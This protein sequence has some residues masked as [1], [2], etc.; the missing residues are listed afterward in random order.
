MCNR[1]R[2]C[3]TTADDA[4]ES[5]RGHGATDGISSHAMG[6][7]Y[8]YEGNQTDALPRRFSRCRRFRLNTDGD[9]RP[10]VRVVGAR[11]VVHYERNTLTFARAMG[12]TP[13]SPGNSHR[14]LPVSLLPGRAWSAPLRHSR[15]RRRCHHVDLGR[16]HCTDSLRCHV[17]WTR[18]RD[19]VT[20]TRRRHQ[21]RAPRGVHCKH[22]D[23][24][25]HVVV[26]TTVDLLL[27][28]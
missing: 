22:L 19:Q 13:G 5:S 9:R 21:Q 4:G 3:D 7:A 11:S 6:S 1:V 17:P 24:R 18:Q 23:P 10:C 12:S 20:W 25:V 16:R 14:R 2:V 15:H 28:S 8:P 27:Q 26:R